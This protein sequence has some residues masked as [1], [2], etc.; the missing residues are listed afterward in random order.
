MPRFLPS[1]SWLIHGMA[2][3][4]YA[5]RASGRSPLPR[6]APTKTMP[7]KMAALAMQP[8]HPVKRRVVL[9]SNDSTG[10]EQCKPGRDSSLP[11]HLC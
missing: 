7:A 3:T 4:S 2:Y 8:E 10:G 6:L 11:A 9:A 1:D 5:E